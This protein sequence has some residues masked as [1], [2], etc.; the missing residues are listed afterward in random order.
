MCSYSWSLKS[1][2]RVGS[3]KKKRNNNNKVAL[4]LVLGTLLRIKSHSA[5][6]CA[7]NEASLNLLLHIRTKKKLSIFAELAVPHK[8]ST[9]SE[10]CGQQTT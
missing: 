10:H 2:G 3:A 1:I 9:L 4:L 7:T 5:V 8:L 6:V